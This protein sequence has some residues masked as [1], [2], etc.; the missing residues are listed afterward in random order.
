M[1]ESQPT[2]NSQ[3]IPISNPVTPVDKFKDRQKKSDAKKA[4]IKY[5][6]KPLLTLGELT[7]LN[8]K[9]KKPYRKP[10]P[11]IS[12]ARLSRLIANINP[13]EISKDAEFESHYQS[14]QS[15]LNRCHPDIKKIFHRSEISKYIASADH[16]TIHLDTSIVIQITPLVDRKSKYLI[17]Q[18]VSGRK[19]NVLLDITG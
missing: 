6:V 2:S 10:L 18:R 16:L 4:Y 3:P 17:T 19:K 8:F 9:A 1:T 7:D 15:V 12:T 5:N 14:I 13:H 11:S